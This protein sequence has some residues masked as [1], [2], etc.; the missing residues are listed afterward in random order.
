MNEMLEGQP[1]P[2]SQNPYTTSTTIDCSRDS[3]YV[4]S[5]AMDCFRDS[6]K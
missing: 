3:P 6:C 2:N 1:D 5:I 4:T